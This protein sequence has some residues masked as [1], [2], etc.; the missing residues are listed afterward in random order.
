MHCEFLVRDLGVITHETACRALSLLTS[1]LYHISGLKSIDKL[2]KVWAN[3]LCILH[4][5]R[6]S[7]RGAQPRAGDTLRLR[8]KK[9]AARSVKSSRKRWE[10]SNARKIGVRLSSS[11]A[12]GYWKC[13]ITSCASY[14]FSSF[15]KIII[16]CSR[17]ADFPKFSIV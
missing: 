2:H 12:S 10:E 14:S 4:N 17:T 7:A 13:L 1:L 8:E 3:F 11:S 15:S 9:K 5:T 6:K 16:C